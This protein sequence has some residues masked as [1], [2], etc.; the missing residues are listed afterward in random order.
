MALIK[1]PECGKD[2]SDKASACP[3]CGFPIANQQ[4]KNEI[5]V[6]LEMFKGV[7][8]TQ[9]VTIAETGGKTL[10]S[11][12]SG[13]VAEFK[14]DKRTYVEITYAFNVMHYGGSCTGYID[15]AKGNK[16]AVSV[17][18]GMFKTVLAFQSVDI[19]DSE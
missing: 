18:I 10:W 19:I 4:N 17:R 3:V 16:Y 14:V 9:F 11:G 6:K 1:C 8:G 7:G 5:K 12:D 2:V 15:P 13:Q